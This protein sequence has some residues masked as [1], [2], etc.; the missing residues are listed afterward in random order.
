MLTVA[1]SLGARGLGCI[2]DYRNKDDEPLRLVKGLVGLP[3]ES[4][5]WPLDPN[6]SDQGSLGSCTGQAVLDAVEDLDKVPTQWSRLWGYLGGRLALN[7]LTLNDYIINPQVVRAK[8]AADTGAMIRDVVSFVNRE[9]L[10]SEALH[11]Y[12]IHAFADLPE[13]RIRAQA[14]RNRLYGM[15][16]LNNAEEVRVALHEGHPLVLG[17]NVYSQFDLVGQ[18]GEYRRTSGRV[19]GGHA[20][21]ALKHK[22]SKVVP[23]FGPGATLCRNSW[24]GGW[25][26]YHPTM[27]AQILGKGFFWMP[28][29]VMDSDDVSDIWALIKE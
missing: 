7:G 28:D 21:R 25:G 13:A 8:M 4:P 24:G 17:F 23:G 16:Y 27:A 22:K 6:T 1:T 3:D 19:L 29:E 14:K 15:R 20:V 11:P 2:P 18:D 9:G 10:I 12:A 26:C 5:D